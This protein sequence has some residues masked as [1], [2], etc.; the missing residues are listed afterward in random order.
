MSNEIPDEFMFQLLG[1][2]LAQGELETRKLK[3]QVEELVKLTAT[4]QEKIDGLQQEVEDAE[5][6]AEG[7]PAQAEG[8]E[9]DSEADATSDEGEEVGE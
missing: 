2:V 4:L 6:R 1:E 7:E 9:D 8:A 3:G 5:A